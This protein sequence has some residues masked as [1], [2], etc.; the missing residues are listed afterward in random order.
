[1]SIKSIVWSI[2]LFLLG[3]SQE[4]QTEQHT[5]T[6]VKQ[7][8]QTGI[9]AISPQALT[10]EEQGLLGSAYYAGNPIFPLVKTVGG[11]NM[12]GLNYFGP[13]NDITVI[14]FSM[15]QLDSYRAKHAK[16]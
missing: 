11:L 2:H 1:M 12:D 9:N 15:S 4:P 8:E 10:A 13:T 3:C 16:G 7:A 14:G 5:S 6:Q